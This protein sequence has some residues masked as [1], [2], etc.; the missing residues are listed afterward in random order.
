MSI[1]FHPLAEEYPLMPAF[2]L[3]RMEEGM[4]RH[5]FDARFPI[6]KYQGKILDGRNRLIASERA[7][8]K[9]VFVEFKGTEE[10]ARL[11][12]QLANEERRHLAQE[13]LQRRRQ[14]RL[15]RVT[16]ARQEGQSLR[17]IAEKEG[18]SESQVR[19]DIEEVKSTAPPGAV[20]PKE[21]TVT[22]KDG[23][24]RTA[25]PV[26]PPKSEPVLCERCTR[27]QR[28]GQ[29]PVK[30]CPDCKALTREAGDDSAE[31]DAE[32]AANRKANRENGKPVY[33]DRVFTD[34]LGKLSREWNTRAKAFGNTAGAKATQVAIDGVCKAW[35]SW[36]REK[37]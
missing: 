9:P 21:G 15:Q 35:E 23:R 1:P 18:V 8:V 5:G 33:D 28:T 10:E 11:F 25:N 12:V 16:E 37:P 27:N 24:T 36:R 6:V 19:R 30:N 17:T 34:L 3:G 13:W 20:E 29:A 31:I 32:R 4:R 22:G 14:E 26:R 7:G 2:E